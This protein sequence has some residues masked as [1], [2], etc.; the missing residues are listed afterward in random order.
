MS[1]TYFVCPLRLCTGLIESYNRTQET[2]VINK[3]H[4]VK[5][6]QPEQ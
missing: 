1:Y 3:F 2:I 6:I 5:C 4:I